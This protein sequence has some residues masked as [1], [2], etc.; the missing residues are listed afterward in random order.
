MFLFWLWWL[1]WFFII[2]ILAAYKRRVRWLLISLFNR[3]T[4]RSW[5][6][7]PFERRIVQ[8]LLTFLLYRSSSWTKAR[9]KLMHTAIAVQT[10]SLNLGLIWCQKWSQFKTTLALGPVLQLIFKYFFITFPTFLRLCRKLQNFR[11]LYLISDAKTH[12]FILLLRGSFM[13]FFL[14]LLLISLAILRILSLTFV[15]C[16][17][18]L[19]DWSSSVFLTPAWFRRGSSWFTIYFVLKSEDELSIIVICWAVAPI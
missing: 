5:F 19:T 17:F 4:L 9:W 10:F 2:F 11:F 13:L 3:A 15:A 6:F 8:L 7:K 16:Y 12:S 14:S 18:L 1:F